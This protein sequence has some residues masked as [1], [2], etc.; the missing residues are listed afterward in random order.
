MPSDRHIENWI[1]LLQ[2]IA[3][4][5]KTLE[6]EYPNTKLATIQVR[7]CYKT[8]SK[9]TDLW[10]G[11]IATAIDHLINDIY[12]GDNGVADRR[13]NFKQGDWSK[14]NVA[15]VETF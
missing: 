6:H 8:K 11:P 4:G 2:Q 15:I 5:I 13:G 1:D 7:L 14:A 12:W 3:D 10:C 9:T